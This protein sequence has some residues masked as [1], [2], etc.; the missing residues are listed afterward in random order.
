[1]KISEITTQD[2]KNYAR[3]YHSEDDYLFSAILVACKSFISSYTGLILIDDP[4][5]T[6]IVE[7]NCDDHEDLSIALMVLASEMYENR[8]YSVQES[9][10]NPVVKSILDMHSINLL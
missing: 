10:V 5:T 7:K 9:K 3:V 8:I 6:D 2:L 1:M 4:A